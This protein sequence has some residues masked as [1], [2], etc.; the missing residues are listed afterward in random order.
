MGIY[1]MDFYVQLSRP[2]DRVQLCKRRPCKVSFQ[3]GLKMDKGI[4]WFQTKFDGII[5]PCFISTRERALTSERELSASGHWPAGRSSIF[6][7][8][9][10]W[11]DACIYAFFATYIHT[12]T[13]AYIR[14]LLLNGKLPRVTLVSPR[15]LR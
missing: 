1:G 6:C 9:N 10:I 5:L 11:M 2:G 12:F 14:L 4:K 15:A 8:N 13:Y 7:S 3:H